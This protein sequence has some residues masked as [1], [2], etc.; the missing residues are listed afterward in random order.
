MIAA[1]EVVGRAFVTI[2]PFDRVTLLTGPVY[3]AGLDGEGAAATAG[4]ER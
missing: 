4:D 2:F 1:E 3:G